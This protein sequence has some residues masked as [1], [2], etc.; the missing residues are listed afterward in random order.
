MKRRDLETLQNKGRSS[1]A[2][3]KR[4]DRNGQADPLK[5]TRSQ[6]RPCI[7]ARLP[8]LSL[9]SRSE[10]SPRRGGL[11]GRTAWPPQ[12]RPSNEAA[13]WAEPDRATPPTGPHL[14]QRGRGRPQRVWGLLGTTGTYEFGLPAVHR[15]LG[16]AGSPGRRRALPTEPLVLPPTAT[17]RG[18]RGAVARPR[19]Q[20][21]HGRCRERGGKEGRRLPAVGHRPGGPAG[22]VRLRLA[23]LS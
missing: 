6:R 3:T 23:R 16:A 2:R 10:T 9:G 1:Q 14:G 12:H 13:R 4:S 18:G 21:L 5:L 7:P 20:R 22:A 8:G 19:P 17:R 11:A 15:L